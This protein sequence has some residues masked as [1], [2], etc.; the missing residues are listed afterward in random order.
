MASWSTSRRAR[1]G[2][3]VT[4][5]SIVVPGARSIT[6]VGRSNPSSTPSTA[7]ARGAVYP[8]S[9][10][11]PCTAASR[12]AWGA[13]DG[14]G[15]SRTTSGPRHSG[16]SDS[17][18]RSTAWMYESNPPA[19]FRGS[20]A[21]VTEPPKCPLAHV[22]SACA[23]QGLAVTASSIVVP[24]ARSITCVGRSNPSSTP[25]T[26]RARGAVYPRSAA[27]PWTAASRAA[28]GA[29]DGD[30]SRRTTSGSRH[31]GK[32]LAG[33]VDRVDVRVEATGDVPWSTGDGD[34]AAEVLARPGRQRAGHRRGV[35]R[36]EAHAR[37]ARR[38][39]ASVRTS[40]RLQNA[41]RTRCRP[42]A[43]SS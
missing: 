31:S 8:R 10:A 15:S 24:G 32:R 3:A 33:Q 4:A 9:A 11:H 20:P 13:R 12:A 2:L 38:S 34:G 36:V 30:G 19:M 41:K 23:R 1:Q 35:A 27:H 6:C 29:L 37:E 14:D 22:A 43:G 21:T 18:A 17:P 28:W 39:A 25:S 40:M 7:R 16:G 26:A 5:S 42:V